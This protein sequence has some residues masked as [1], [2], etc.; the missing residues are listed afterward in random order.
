MFSVL[1]NMAVTIGDIAMREKS[2]FCNVASKLIPSDIS[3]VWET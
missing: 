2:G 3:K 1:K